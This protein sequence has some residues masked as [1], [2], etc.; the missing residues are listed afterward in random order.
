MAPS[1]SLFSFHKFSCWTQMSPTSLEKPFSAYVHWRLAGMTE[2]VRD[3]FSVLCFFR[4]ICDASLT[5]LFID[6]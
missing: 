2:N 5:L 3:C 1:P 4:D 6:V